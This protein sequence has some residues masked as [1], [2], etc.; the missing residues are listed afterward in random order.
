MKMKS[1][2]IT[3]SST[4]DFESIMEKQICV[5]RG[6]HSGLALDLIRELIGDY[7]AKHDPYRID[8]V[9]FVIHADI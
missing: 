5:F 4:L 9:H 2:Q 6:S 1:I 3:S 7:G 8:N